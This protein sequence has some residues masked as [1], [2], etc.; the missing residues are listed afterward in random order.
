MA[1]ENGTYSI[2]NITHTADI[3]DFDAATPLSE[4]RY[5]KF[6]GTTT[7]TCD[8]IDVRMSYLASGLTKTFP[9]GRQSTS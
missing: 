1:R 8:Q 7:P 6:F 3:L 9:D 5:L 2:M 4:H